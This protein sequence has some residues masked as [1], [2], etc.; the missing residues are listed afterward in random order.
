MAWAVANGG[1][2]V[3]PARAA[4][5]GLMTPA[6]RRPLRGGTGAKKRNCRHAEA[7]GKM[8]RAGVAGNEN[9][10][11]FQHGE[12]QR[13]FGN[14]RQHRRVRREFFQFHHQVLLRARRRAV[15]KATRHPAGGGKPVEFSPVTQRPFLFRL[16]GSDMA[17]DGSL[18]AAIFCAAAANA[19][20]ERISAS[21]EEGAISHAESRCAIR[22]DS[23]CSLGFR[24]DALVVAKPAA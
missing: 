6:K 21:S 3:A 5:Q 24:R 11:A 2:P 15:V 23:C 9:L 7:G 16:A 22:A 12:K 13:Q 10:R 14:R 8:Q 19:G 18:A 20:S 1:I 17:K 4:G